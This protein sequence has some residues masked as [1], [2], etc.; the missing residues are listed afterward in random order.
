MKKSIFLI[1]IFLFLNSLIVVKALDKSLVSYVADKVKIDVINYEEISLDKDYEDEEI[2]FNDEAFSI[3]S[4]KEP[5]FATIEALKY[6][7][8]VANPGTDDGVSFHYLLLIISSIVIIFI[9]SSRR[10]IKIGR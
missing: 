4:E 9:S 7:T 6:S 1:I 10:L 5:S 8:Y 2:L 3:E